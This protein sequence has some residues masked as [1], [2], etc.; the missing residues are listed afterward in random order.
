MAWRLRLNNFGRLKLT[1]T[2]VMLA[3]LTDM[4]LTNWMLNISNE[5]Y[6]SNPLFYPE[7]GLPIMVL[8]FIITDH[9]FPRNILFDNIFYAF[10][11]TGWS[12]PIQN[13][14]VFFHV[15]SGVNVFIAL[16]V[17]YVTSYVLL[18]FMANRVN[19]LLLISMGKT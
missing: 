2:I 6:E 18:C 15:T 8:Y 19:R 12:A 16:P 3:F 5:F 1:L 14:F 17:I 11:V 9:F 10:S 7:I 13:I 4:L